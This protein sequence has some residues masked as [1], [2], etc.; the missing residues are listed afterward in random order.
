ML[1]SSFGFFCWNLS[2]PSKG[3]PSGATRFALDASVDDL[4]LDPGFFAVGLDV[5]V[6]NFDVNFGFFNAVG[7]A[8]FFLAEFF[9]LV[10]AAFPVA[11]SSFAFSFLSC[12]SFFR[13][14]GSVFCL[15]TS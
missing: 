13:L 10:C 8:D 7:L 9:L 15:K 6:D 12:L 14:C 2:G 1:P 11:F 4:G 3:K 5:L